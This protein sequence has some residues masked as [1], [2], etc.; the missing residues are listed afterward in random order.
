MD[1][2]KEC[3]RFDPVNHYILFTA[4]ELQQIKKKISRQ[5]IADLEGS[6][7]YLFNQPLQS[8]VDKKVVLPEEIDAHDYV[9]LATYYWPNPKTPSGLPYIS[10]D[11]MA[12]P[13]GEEYEKDKLRSLSYLVYTLGILYYLTDDTRYY[14]CLKKHCEVFFIDPK[15]RMNPNMDHAQMIKGVN[16]GRGIGMIDYTGNMTYALFLLKQLQILG[17]LEEDFYQQLK[18]WHVDF[19]R[20]MNQSP[21]ALQE[22]YATNNHG[23]MYVLGCLT[24]AYFIDCKEDVLSYVY[25]MIEYHLLHQFAD[26]GSL[27]QELKRTKSKSYSLM[28]LKAFTDFAIL[29]NQ[30]QIDL[31]D[32]SW[33]YKKIKSYIPLGVTYLKQHLIENQNWNYPQ[34]TVFDSATLLPLIHFSKVY[35]HQP[36]L[37]ENNVKNGLIDDILYGLCLTLLEEN[38]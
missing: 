17:Y 4:D 14:D 23:S 28:G 27:P 12:N 15:S 25:H 18:H 22:R 30:Y 37:F 11:G 35:L 1:Y 13:E 32:L 16:T 3:I 24:V 38:S 6:L 26:D 36:I 33:Y 2:F 20:W 21:I 8:V 10:K 31:I 7:A 29:A 9:S 5:R 19:Y 34:I